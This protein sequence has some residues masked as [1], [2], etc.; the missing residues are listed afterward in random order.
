[1]PQ[2]RLSDAVVDVTNGVC[3]ECNAKR[4]ALVYAQVCFGFKN[5]GANLV[6]I[7]TVRKHMDNVKVR[8]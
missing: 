5:N 6:P 7:K 3:K 1:M 4:P 2:S 8:G